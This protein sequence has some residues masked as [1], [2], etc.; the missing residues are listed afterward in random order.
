MCLKMLEKINFTKLNELLT[1]ES[2][3]MEKF[4]REKFPVLDRFGNP[5]VIDD[6]DE[7]KIN[8]DV[9]KFI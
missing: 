4:I 9:E 1:K 5:Y 7:V 8:G 6:T 3:K 2:I